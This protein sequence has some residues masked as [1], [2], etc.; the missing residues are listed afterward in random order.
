MLGTKTWGASISVCYSAESIWDFYHLATQFFLDGTHTANLS[1]FNI[2]LK[3]I[4]RS[5]EGTN[6]LCLLLAHMAS[7]MANC[8]WAVS[9]DHRTQNKQYHRTGVSQVPLQL[10][11]WIQPPLL[12]MILWLLR[13]N[14]SN[15]QGIKF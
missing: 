7:M 13:H 3:L 5:V 6:F 10:I 12:P 14:M 11:C 8:D 2:M 15:V 4:K 1:Q 9:A